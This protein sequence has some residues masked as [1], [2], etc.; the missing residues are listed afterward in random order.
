MEHLYNYNGLPI[1]TA[2]DIKKRHYFVDVISDKIKNILWEQ[3]RAWEFCQ[4]ES[5][6]LIP[7]LMVN[8]NYT[9]DDVYFIDG[10][11]A[12]KPE[13]T[14]ASYFYAEHLL[15]NQ[16]KLPV[17]VYQASKSYRKE[18]DQSTKHCRFKEF[19]QLEFQCVYSADTKN[20]Y[21]HNIIGQLGNMFAEILGLPTRIVLSDRLPS[22][23]IKTIDIEVNNGDKWMEIASISLRNDFT[24]RPIMKNR[25]V[26][27]LVLEIAIG[28]DRLIYNSTIKTTMVD[29]LI[30]N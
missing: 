23:S 16:H 29:D 15:K 26:E 7:K 18:Q 12:L 5:C 1:Y 6:S 30:G 25:E 9:N 22:Y 3:N 4:I 24:Y 13:T 21:Q 11:L 2:E 14:T 19:Y 27:C 8:S 28:L 17:C 20:D 10:D